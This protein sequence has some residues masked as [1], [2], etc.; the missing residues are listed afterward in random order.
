MGKIRL[1][2]VFWCED[3]LLKDLFPTPCSIPI[4]KN[5]LLAD[6]L[7]NAGDKIQLRRGLNNWEIAEAGLFQQKIQSMRIDDCKGLKPVVSEQWNVYC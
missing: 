7:P 5:C 6:Y 3:G 4:N 2:T 1:W